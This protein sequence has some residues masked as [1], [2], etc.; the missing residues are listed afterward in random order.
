[1]ATTLRYHNYS[2]TLKISAIMTSL[3]ITCAC[4][5]PKSADNHEVTIAVEAS[6]SRDTNATVTTAVLYGD[7]VG[8]SF[9][10][11]PTSLPY[12]HTLQIPS[13]VTLSVDAQQKE[14]VPFRCLILIDGKEVSRV[15]SSAFNGS[16]LSEATCSAKT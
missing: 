4:G 1:M 13:K 6:I 14:G 8:N 12:K 9:T 2:V 3:F 16:S 15:E 7:T 11:R 5:E 10:A